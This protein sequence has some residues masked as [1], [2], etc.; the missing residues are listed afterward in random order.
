[1]RLLVDDKVDVWVKPGDETRFE[2]GHEGVHLF[3]LFQCD[4]CWFRN[5]KGSDPVK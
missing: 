2:Q 4:L 1:M 5:L 3:Y